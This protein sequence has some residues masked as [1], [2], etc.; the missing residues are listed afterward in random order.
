[1]MKYLRPI[2]ILLA[3]S[4]AICSFYHFKSGDSSKMA[5]KLA[6]VKKVVALKKIELKPIVTEKVAKSEKTLAKKSHR[7]I[8]SIEKI[9]IQYF[10]DII[11][12]TLDDCPRQLTHS[13]YWSEKIS[14]ID[15]YCSNTKELES[16]IEFQTSQKYLNG[17]LVEYNQSVVASEPVSI[18]FESL[19]QLS[20]VFLWIDG[21]VVF[22]IKF[23]SN[24]VSSYIFF[25]E[26]VEQFYK[27]YNNF[28]KLYNDTEKER[29]RMQPR[30]KIL[31]EGKRL[32]ETLL[33]DLCKRSKHKKTCDTHQ[34]L[35]DFR[36]MP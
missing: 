22:G 19:E 2:L 9:V 18:K 36:Y 6:P 23:K 32:I 29:K 8:P 10:P 20:E 12:E 33:Y 3:I 30:I 13:K 35:V 7:P 11:F 34:D 17:R 16:G 28:Y 31:K 1:M 24:L 21:A 4:A 5:F 26:E 14:D 27:K 15:S 25:N